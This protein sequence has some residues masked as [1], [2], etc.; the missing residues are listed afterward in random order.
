MAR[1]IITLILMVLLG[2]A[3]MNAQTSMYLKLPDIEGESQQQGHEEEIELTQVSWEVS[4]PDAALSGRTRARTSFSGISIAK[5]TDLASNT[6]LDFLARNKTL[7][8][9]ILTFST[10]S[11]DGLKDYLIYELDNVRITSFKMEANE[12]DSKPQ[13]YWTL[14]FEKINS[15]YKQFNNNGRL[16]EEVEF[17]YSLR[18]GS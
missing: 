5:N 18:T 14:S 9:V 17:E 12:K 7:R 16:E 13:E 1:T 15:L 4:I 10:N 3:T 11:S 8:N 2:F 6:M